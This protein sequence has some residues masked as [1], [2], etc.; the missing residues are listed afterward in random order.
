MDR[1]ATIGTMLIGVRRPMVLVALASARSAFPVG[2][3]RA[4]RASECVHDSMPA[5]RLS[6]L[7]R[8][9]ST[10]QRCRRM[11]NGG[12][13]LGD[14]RASIHW[15]GS[16]RAPTALGAGNRDER[17]PGSRN[18]M[19]IDR[20]PRP[21]PRA[22]VCGTRSSVWWPAERRPSSSVHVVSTGTATA[23]ATRWQQ[24]RPADKWP[25][26]GCATVPLVKGVEARPQREWI[27]WI[28]NIGASTAR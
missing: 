22:T 7:Q 21:H 17:W 23:R 5:K 19:E 16:E 10:T 1:R 27:H 28:G 14:W 26:E 13:R 9:A 4:G 24:R 2:A 20:Q 8:S 3:A 6:R 11:E 25:A 12:R 18:Q 15:R